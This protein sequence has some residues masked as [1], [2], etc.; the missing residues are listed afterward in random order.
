MT[1]SLLRF[2]VG[3]RLC[4]RLGV[5]R[6][7]R[8]SVDIS[9]LQLDAP[10]TKLVQRNG[11]ASDGTAHEGA[12]RHHLDLAIEIAKLG[13]TLET[14]IAFETVQQFSDSSFP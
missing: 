10:I 5:A 14:K 8:V 4:V 13:L 9:L 3:R 6:Q 11:A 7:R 2:G 1:E 12:R